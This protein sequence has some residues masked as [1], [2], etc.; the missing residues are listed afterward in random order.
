MDSIGAVD[1]F[2]IA[3]CKAINNHSSEVQH[4]AKSAYYDGKKLKDTIKELS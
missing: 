3:V 4:K 2:I 1:R